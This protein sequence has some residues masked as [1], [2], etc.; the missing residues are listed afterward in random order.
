MQ[1]NGIGLGTPTDDGPT[2]LRRSDRQSMVSHRSEAEQFGRSD[3]P[4]PAS[5][6]ARNIGRQRAQENLANHYL[7]QQKLEE[8]S[9]IYERLIGPACDSPSVYNNLAAI[10]WLR[11]QPDAMEPVLHRALELDPEYPDAHYN[12]GLALEAKGNTD[13]AISAYERAIKLNPDHGDARVNLGLALVRKGEL[14]A[15]IA[16]HRKALHRQPGGA[17]LH[18]NLGLALMAKGLHDQAVESFQ[19]ALRLRPAFAA[20]HASLGLALKE[21]NKLQ[22]AIAAYRQALAIEPNDASAQCNLGNALHHIGDQQGAVK[23]FKKAIA[24]KPDCVEALS[25]LGL[26]SL[27]QDAIDEAIDYFLQ[28]LKYQP[29]FATAHYNLGLAYQKQGQLD[30]AAKAYGKAIAH[31][32]GHIEAHAN[33]GSVHHMVGNLK[34]AI[35]S[36]Q[37]AIT[38]QPDHADSHSNLAMALLLEGDYARG[39]AAYEWRFEVKRSG[40]MLAAKPRAERWQGEHLAPGTT[41][42]LICEQGLGDTLQFMRYVLPL[43]QRNIAV[44]LCAQAK[45]HGLIQTSGLDPQPLTPEQASQVSEGR[46]APLL[47]IPRHLGVKPSKPIISEPYIK[48]AEDL[49]VKWQQI[50]C[51]DTKPIIA[52]NWQGNPEH[53]T[54]NSQ[55]RSLPLETFAPLATLN[56]ISLLSLQKGFGSEQLANCGFRDRFVA[57]QDLIDQTWDFGETAAIIANC[58]LVISSDTSIAHLAA[59]LGKTT[60]LLLKQ[61]PEWRWGLKGENSFWYPSMRLFRQRERGNWTEV[62]ERVALELQHW[63]ENSKIHHQ[64]C[65]SPAANMDQRPSDGQ[66]AG[67]AGFD[68]LALEQQAQDLIKQGNYDAAESIYQDLIKAGYNNPITLSN[69]AAICHLRGRRNEMITLLRQALAIKP[70]YP[71]ALSNLGIALQE[72]GDPEA[73]IAAYRAALSLQPDGPN[74]LSNLGT[75][76]KEQGDLD[77]AI[78]CF[79]RAIEI[80][81]DYPEAHYNRAN[82]LE[83]LGDVNGAINAYERAIS[84]KADYPVAQKNL[85]MALLLQGDYGRGWKHYEWRFRCPDSPS[86]PH[87]IPKARLWSGK[88][89]LANANLLV[90]SEQGL[91]DTLQF[92]RYVLPLKQQ[93]IAVSLCAQ[94]KLHGLIQASGI[95]PH[96]LTPDQAHGIVHGE[97]IPLLSLPMHLGVGPNLP[98]INEPYL[99]TTEE[100][101]EQWQKILAQETK[102]IIAIHW[103]GNPKHEKTNSQGR[104]LPL[105]TFAPLATLN[106][107]SLLSLQKGFGSEQLQSCPFRDR[108]VGCQEL[109]DQTWDFGETAAIIH[110]CALVITSDSAVAHLAAGLGKP[111]WLLLKKVPEWRWGLQGE[112]SFWYPSMRLFRQQER[113]NWA[114]VMERVTR[115]LQAVL[116]ADHPTAGG[117]DHRIST[118]TGQP[119]RQRGRLI[120]DIKKQAIYA[121]NLASAR[122]RR[123]SLERMAD[124]HGLSLDI[125]AAV[126][127]RLLSRT[128]MQQQAPVEIEWESLQGHRDAISTPAQAA[129]CLSHRAIWQ[130]IIANN[131]EGAIILEDDVDFVGRQTFELPAHSDFVFLANRANHN[132]KGEV[133]GPICGSEAY[134]VTAKGCLK[135]LEIF[136]TIKMPVDIQWLPQMR[137]LIDSNHIMTALHDPARPILEAHVC[138]DVFRL[139]QS[140]CQSQIT[141]SPGS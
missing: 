101:I 133:R 49:V 105:S 128:E 7:G 32:P 24:I 39:W 27:E 138:P 114:E 10:Y 41:L 30:Q 129:C 72:Q 109:I 107:I 19:Q 22:E 9:Q 36:Y 35:N 98:I 52:I 37:S 58:A 46:W 115:E 137:G 14:D 84:L 126:D 122:E 31:R 132:G 124:R 136:N 47:S 74:T 104:S 33:L 97:W 91:G 82:I 57:C 116:A 110:H 121:I 28:A 42:L 26:A 29:E 102:P 73:A 48:V 15:A 12:L 71:E 80:K 100:R 90:V 3:G 40:S 18:L 93:G 130:R 113:G 53:E 111:T 60:W 119:E 92:M 108:F 125:V 96:P 44:S 6:R 78:Q 106:G 16:C 139:N 17:D 134:Y 45:L 56:G 5:T 75:L 25:N 61:I 70:N 123:D 99:K 51:S 85:S 55:G 95:D 118:T 66:E 63:L 112:Q 54:T 64:P 76:L 88:H 87:A 11:G 135:L 79:E 117:L 141:P 1:P 34:D 67:G 127:G 69:L 38:L 13:H 23:A 62:M 21:L 131:L 2:K 59:G 65:N 68:P 83:E 94:P 89:L 50:L 81:P 140:S 8:A 120:L 20:A 77:S 86:A 103:Q 43:K 4:D